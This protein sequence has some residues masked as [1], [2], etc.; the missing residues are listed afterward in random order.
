ML[1]NQASA[2]VMSA[3]LDSVSAANTAAATSGAGKWLDVRGFDGEVLVTQQLGAFTGTTPAIAGKL[4]SASDA[5]GTGAADI[6][7]YTFTTNAANSTSSIAVDPKKVPGGFLGYVGTVTGT[8]PTI[9]VSV[10][11]GGKRHV[12]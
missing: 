6:A 7:G 4:Q 1:L 11:A 9:Q 10:M 8:T 2:A 5:N 3:L 12:T